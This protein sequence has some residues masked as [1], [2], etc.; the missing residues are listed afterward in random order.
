MGK[1]LQGVGGRAGRMEGGSIQTP[2]P[3]SSPLSPG[4]V[5][6]LSWPLAPALSK[7]HLP[8]TQSLLETQTL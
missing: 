2:G 8:P 7:A 1:V 3:W 4:L 6:L 5:T